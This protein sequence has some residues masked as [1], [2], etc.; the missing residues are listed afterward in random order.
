MDA[1][2]LTKALIARDSVSPDQSDCQNLLAQYLQPLGFE[3]THLPF[4]D[5]KNLWARKGD[6]SPLFVF[7]GHTDVVPA[8]PIEAW[9][10]PPFE[11][12]EKDGRLY[13]RGAAD[14][15]SSLA[16][17]IIATKAFVTEHPAH[18]GSIGFLITGDE[19][20]SAINGTI[21][22]MA[23]LL[24]AG[25]EIDWCLIGE[26]SSDKVTGDVIKVGRRGSLNGELLVK[27]KQGHVAYPE[28]ASNPIHQ[29]TRALNELVHSEWDTGNEF[30]PP[31]SF[32][33]SN[34]HGG[35]GANN[36]IPG[37]LNITFNFRFSSETTADALKLAVHEILDACELDYELA[38]QLS[39]VPFLTRE[40]ALVNAVQKAISETMNL[41][42]QLSTS[43]GT[44]DGRFIAPHGIEVVEL[45][46]V[47]ES[48]HQTNENIRLEE[49]EH[50]TQMYLRLLTHLLL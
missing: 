31:T 34:I 3:T 42:T 35:T 36:V 44:S 23:H 1:I 14:M 6:S 27:G 30:F 29:A 21:K 11:A 4:G 12:I 9:D 50:L 8:G 17:M 33:I 38:W 13:G 2:E 18:K 26:P 7:A 40:G 45:G 49:I 43:G 28:K 19:E 37:D 10:N 25:I 46:P 20:A 32:Q 15:K 39:G 22:V 47:N 24:D 48:I 5:V 41:E 16:A